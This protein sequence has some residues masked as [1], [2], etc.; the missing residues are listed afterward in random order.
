[1]K[2]GL[3]APGVD[4]L[5][6]PVRCCSANA[7]F[8]GEWSSNRCVGCGVIALLYGGD[9][10]TFGCHNP[11]PRYARYRGTLVSRDLRPLNV[12]LR[13]LFNEPNSLENI[14]DVVYPAFS[15]IESLVKH[16]EENGGITLCTQ[17]SR[18]CFTLAAVLRSRM[19][20]GADRI[21]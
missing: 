17:V 11:H 7:P 15:N 4:K 21:K 9:G 2:G 6:D 13:L 16:I 10:E 18:F 1:M 12:V 20:P 5:R 14:R 19:P 8:A 3:V